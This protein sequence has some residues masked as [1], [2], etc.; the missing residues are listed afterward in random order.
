MEKKSNHDYVGLR[1]LL[2]ASFWLKLK[3][4][5]NLSQPD[6]RRCFSIV[7]P[8]AIRTE[9]VFFLF[10]HDLIEFLQ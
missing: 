8:T 7:I 6:I 4:C 3:R 2:T 10:N 9:T 5:G 1:K